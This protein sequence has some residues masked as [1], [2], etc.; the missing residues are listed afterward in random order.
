MALVTHLRNQV[1]IWLTIHMVTFWRH[2][3]W[4]SGRLVEFFNAQLTHLRNPVRIWLK[5]HIISFWSHY[6]WFSSRLIEHLIAKFTHLQNPV[7]IWLKRQMFSFWLVM[8]SSKLVKLL[9]PKSLIYEI[10]SE[11]DSKDTC[12]ESL[13]MV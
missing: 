8:I 10:L 3:W 9:W 7:R 11:F 5:R 4:F 12:S 2:C 6:L 13:V 1:R